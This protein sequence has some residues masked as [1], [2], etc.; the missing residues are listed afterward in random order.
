MIK[1]QESVECDNGT[2]GAQH[3]V[4]RAV[5][6]IGAHLIEHGI[7]HLRSQRAL[8]DQI[9]KL[10]LL[11]VDLAFEL[12]GRARQIG[13]ANGLVGFLRVLGF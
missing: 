4:I 3:R 10:P 6:N 7:F 11:L 5:G 8:P 1:R 2:G 9:V 12:I 13:R